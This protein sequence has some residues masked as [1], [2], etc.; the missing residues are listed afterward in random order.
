MPN[1]PHTE[2]APIDDFGDGDDIIEAH[3]DRATG[4]RIADGGNPRPPNKH[5]MADIA[6]V[7][8]P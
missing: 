3:I 4:W 1:V 8:P 2:L 7:R 6:L 5:V